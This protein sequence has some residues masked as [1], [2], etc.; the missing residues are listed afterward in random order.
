MIE[1]LQVNRKFLPL[2]ITISL[3]IVVYAFGMI[4]YKGFSSPQVFLNIL[5][6]NAFLFITC[7]GMTF[8][9]LSGGIDLSVGAVIALTTVVSAYMVEEMAVHP[10]IVI[11]FVLL[12]GITMG[13]FMGSIIHFFK[14]QPF[15]VTLSGLFFARGLC[16]LIST[17]S[18]TI[19]HPFYRAASL[20]RIY[21]PGGYFVSISVVIF[22]VVLVLALYLA[23]QTGF[24]RAV[25]AIGGNEQSAR[26]MGLPVGRTKILIYT[27]NGFLSALAGVVFSLYTLSGYGLYVNGLELD[28]IAGVVIGGT[29]LTGG[30]GYVFGTVFGVLIMGLIQVLVIFQGTLS[31]WWTRIVVGLL[32]LFFILIQGA[33]MSGKRKRLTVAKIEKSIEE[34]E[35]EKAVVADNNLVADG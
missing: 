11:P 32:T 20:Y 7:I 1:K 3:F 25:Y 28:A 21:L 18:I 12:M 19:T 22:L 4:Q 14:V 8:V 15:I 2:T 10:F 24:G 27:L 9:I 31:S 34:Q 23:H 16:F 26:L 33:V 35:Q 30:V 5:I 13:L 29:L 17:T 6:D